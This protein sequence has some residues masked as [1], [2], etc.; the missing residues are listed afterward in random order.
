V[1]L[2]NLAISLA[3]AC[4]HR[5]ELATCN[6]DL[7]GVWH[8][9][10]GPPMFVIDHG[11]TL[12][13]HPMAPDAQGSHDIVTAPRVVELTRDA[14]GTIAGQLRRRFMR[15]AD[16]CEAHVAIHV[17]KCHGDTVELVTS[18]VVRPL[19]FAPCTWPA[20]EP[21]RVERWQRE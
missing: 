1:K 5:S 17:T 3:M 14:T 12:E 7:G 6:D 20:P 4:D 2:V 21:T 9:P 15:R 10:D 11:A 19:G 8:V 18:D 16:A 13:A